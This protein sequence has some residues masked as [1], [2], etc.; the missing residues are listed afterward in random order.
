MAATDRT[1]W[2]KAFW[3]LLAR[4]GDFE[5]ADE[6]ANSGTY[7]KLSTTSDEWTEAETAGF[8]PSILGNFLSMMTK[9][10]VTELHTSGSTRTLIEAADGAKLISVSSSPAIVQ[11]PDSPAVGW[12]AYVGTSGPKVTVQTQGSNNILMPKGVGLT[13]SLESDDA[14][15]YVGF[16]YVGGGSEVW[17]PIDSSG[18]WADDLSS[19]TKRYNWDGNVEGAGITDVATFDADGNIAK[20]TVAEAKALLTYAASDVSNDSS[21]TGADVKAALNALLA[22]VN[23]VS[24]GYSRRTRCIDY[25]DCTAAP[26]SE[27][28]GDRYILDFTGGVVH[29]DW[30]GAAKGDI[31]DRGATLWDAQTPSEGWIAYVDLKDDDYLCVD[32]GTLSWE[33][34]PTY[35]RSHADLTDV[36]EDQHHAKQHALGASAVHTSATLAELNA[37]IS[38]ATLGKLTATAPA[39]VTKAAAVVGSSAEV[40]RQDHKHDVSTAAVGDVAAGATAAE[41]SASSLARSDHDHGF[42]ST[43]T[44]ADVKVQ[45]AALGSDS[46]LSRS[47]HKHNT[48]TGTPGTIGEGDTPAGGSATTLARS[49]HTHG[50]P[51]DYTPKAHAP[52]HESGGGDVLELQKIEGS[53]TRHIDV[54]AAMAGVGPTAPT[55]DPQDTYHGRGFDADAEQAYLT[56]EVPGDWDAASDMK[57]IVHW[58]ATS[59]DAVADTEE[60]KWDADYR[61]AEVGETSDQGTLVSITGTHTQSG[62]GADKEKYK[63][64]ITIDHDDANQPLTVGDEVGMLFNRDVTGETTPYS[65]KGIVTRWEI[66]YTANRV[67]Q[68]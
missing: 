6:H 8:L 58:M 44:P 23:A 41:G 28:E 50:S 21:V 13:T 26:P 64:E 30:D 19:P 31:V 9:N 7:L 65:G 43:N 38:D 35:N 2:R 55:E 60:L 52:A 29:A 33:R 54:V 27:V 61:S 36:A 10:L 63:T 32:D 49:D 11:L 4:D 56:W 22:L 39:D 46:E 5:I 66:E 3:R 59:G 68:H 34:R 42:P 40:A 57:L 14:A 25:V 20:M 48:S 12:R 37:L 18:Y 24:S 53:Y 17:L 62:A 47:D 16:I 1:A 45:T 51:A 15:A 67:P